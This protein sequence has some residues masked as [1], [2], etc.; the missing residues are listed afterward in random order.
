VL[1]NERRFLYYFRH[2]SAAYPDG[3]AVP[4]AD[5]GDDSD[6]SDAQKRGFNKFRKANSNRQRYPIGKLLEVRRL[7]TAEYGNRLPGEPV[8]LLD[9]LPGTTKARTQV[10]A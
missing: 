9:E 4:K 3:G 1:V 10:R 6:P 5:R 2:F 8:L 7:G